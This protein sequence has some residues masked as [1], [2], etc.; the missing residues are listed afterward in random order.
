M[1]CPM[2]NIPER[3]STPA[4]EENVIARGR[5]PV[6]RLVP[7][8]PQGPIGRV[9]GAAKGQYGSPPSDAFAPLSVDELEAWE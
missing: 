9:F 2:T 1:R 7:A 8:A 4:G 3:G 6:A 5:I